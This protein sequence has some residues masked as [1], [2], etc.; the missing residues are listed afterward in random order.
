MGNNA[1]ES[2]VLTN[3]LV[4]IFELSIKKLVLFRKFWQWH[5]KFLYFLSLSQSFIIELCDSHFAGSPQPQLPC[6]WLA[7]T[8]RQRICEASGDFCELFISRLRF[9]RPE[10]SD[11]HWI[12]H[13]N[14]EYLDRVSKHSKLFYFDRI[15][16]ILGTAR[17]LAHSLVQNLAHEVIDFNYI[18]VIIHNNIIFQTI[19]PTSPSVESSASCFPAKGIRVLWN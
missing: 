18:L 6:R 1:I 14:W 10:L 12:V 16:M 19:C 15:Q 13:A 2:T 8:C 3:F 9:L 4:Q 17:L 11:Q 7:R 5:Q